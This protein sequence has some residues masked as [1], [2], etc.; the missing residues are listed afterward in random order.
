M[1]ERGLRREEGRSNSFRQG[2]KKSHELYYYEL[3]FT[4]DPGAGFCSFQNGF[5]PIGWDYKEES[6]QGRRKELKLVGP[7]LLNGPIM[8]FHLQCSLGG[9]SRHITHTC[10]QKHF[11]VIYSGLKSLESLIKS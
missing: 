7:I 1:K 10:S 5:P 3:R 11:Q 8:N 9:A 2:Y 4:G 6:C